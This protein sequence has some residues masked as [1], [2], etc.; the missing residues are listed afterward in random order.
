MRRVL[1]IWSVFILVFGAVRES[2]AQESDGPSVV[3]GTTIRPIASDGKEYWLVEIPMVEGDIPIRGEHLSVTLDGGMTWGTKGGFSVESTV[4]GGLR[5]SPS[6]FFDVYT[7]GHFGT[8]LF[9]NYTLLGTVGVEVNVP[10][11][12][13]ASLG[14]GVEYFGRRNRELAGFITKPQWYASGRGVG[15]RVSV[16]MR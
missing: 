14:L 5:W 13:S 2:A 15:V 11:G 16:R 3:L 6:R 1:V 10:A 9:N 7:Q 12:E 4:G 8:F